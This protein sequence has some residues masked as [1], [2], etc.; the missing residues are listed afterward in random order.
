MR[1]KILYILILGI[2][3]STNFKLYSQ[4]NYVNDL[5]SDYDQNYVGGF[6][7]PVFTTLGQGFNSSFITRSDY[8]K[9][10][11]KIGLDLTANAMIIPESQKS[12]TVNVSDEWRNVNTFSKKSG[13]TTYSQRN[14]IEQ[15]TIYGGKSTPLFSTTENSKGSNVTTYLEGFDLSNISAIPNI[16]LNVFLPTQTEVRL[17][18]FGYDGLLSYGFVVNQR[19]DEL[20]GIFGD[21]NKQS[22]ALSLGFNSFG[23][24][25]IDD[26]APSKLAIDLKSTSF[27]FGVNYNYNIIKKLN[28][29]VGAQYETY[30]GTLNTTYIDKL[31]ATPQ[32]IVLNADITTFSNYRATAGLSYDFGFLELHTDVAYVS[33]PMINAGINVFFGSWGL[34]E[35]MID[36]NAEPPATTQPSN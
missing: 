10:E 11:W 4:N 12:F 29:Y 19:I 31:I 3:L 35:E 32:E 18:G 28:L 8:K 20:L 26:T 21:D 34:E 2:F 16:Q 5:F 9:G 17:K 25:Y 33:Q 13:E 22:F 7:K 14:T 1:I 27:A 6:L 36:E 23:V 15:P 30:S 24:D